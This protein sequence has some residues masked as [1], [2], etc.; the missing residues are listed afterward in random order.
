MKKCE[1]CKRR[2]HAHCREVLALRADLL[3]GRRITE[4]DRCGCTCR[5]GKRR[6]RDTSS[7]PAP[8]SRTSRF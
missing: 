7:S 1:A 8:Q 4:E 5:K 2:D 3:G 6:T